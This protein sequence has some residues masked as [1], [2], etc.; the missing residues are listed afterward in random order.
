MATLTPISVVEDPTL[1][2]QARV[3]LDALPPQQAQQPRA[4]AVL[5][6]LAVLEPVPVALSLLEAPL[7]WGVAVWMWEVMVQR[8]ERSP[9]VSAVLA[10]FPAVSAV[11]GSIQSMVRLGTLLA[12]RLGMPVMRLA[13]VGRVAMTAE[14][15]L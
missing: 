4:M 10:L 1:L 9:A 7:A 3:V 5:E 2:P 13:L 12:A 11:L 8:R 6:A 15:V 14:L